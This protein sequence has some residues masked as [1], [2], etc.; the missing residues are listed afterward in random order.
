[1]K[2]GREKKKRKKKKVNILNT[3]G[4]INMMT[5]EMCVDSSMSYCTL[6]FQSGPSRVRT[7]P[8]LASCCRHLSCMMVDPPEGAAAACNPLSVAAA[9]LLRGTVCSVFTC[10]C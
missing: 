5:V 2:D 3:C 9:A 7:Q 4:C 8:W 10:T 1:M 6:A